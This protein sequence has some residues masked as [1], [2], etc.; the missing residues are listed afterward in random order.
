MRLRP[1]KSGRFNGMAVRD[2]DTMLDTIG[3]NIKTTGNI[4]R[5]KVAKQRCWLRIVHLPRGK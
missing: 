4:R 3:K 1:L 2:D 5:K